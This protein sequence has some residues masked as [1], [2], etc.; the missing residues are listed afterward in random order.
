MKTLLDSMLFIGGRFLN[1]D[2]LKLASHIA[3]ATNCRLVTDTFVSKIRRGAGLPIIEQVPY[4]AEMAEEFLA[5]VEAIV[6]IG[7]RPPVSFFAYPGKKSFLS[8]EECK[9]IELASP[10]QDG[11][12]ALHALSL[13]HI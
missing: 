13:I 6:F 11:K 3:S 12:Y 5:G 2:C 1:E 9:L 8:P 10:F 4:F 7:T